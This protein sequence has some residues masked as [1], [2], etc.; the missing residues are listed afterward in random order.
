[1]QIDAASCTPETCKFTQTTAALDPP[2]LILGCHKSVG[3]GTLRLHAGGQYDEVSF[4][5][6]DG[7]KERRK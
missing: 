6:R 2:E 1:M 4:W 7:R 3:N 5:N